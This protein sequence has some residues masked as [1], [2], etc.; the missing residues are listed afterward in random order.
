MTDNEIVNALRSK[1]KA[2]CTVCDIKGIV[3]CEQCVY[4][5]TK[6]CLDSINR[7]KA[8][9]ETLQHKIIFMMNIVK[10]LQN[11]N[12]RLIKESLERIDDIKSDKIK[13]V[14]GE[15]ERSV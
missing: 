1:T 10:Q 13:K 15:V 8:E 3:P 2:H 11:D 5:Y 14:C 12:I 6:L 4:H 7:L 9:N